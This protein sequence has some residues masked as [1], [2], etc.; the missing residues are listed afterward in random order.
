MAKQ[1][2][3]ST[4]TFKGII[5]QF[6]IALEK[7]FELQEGESVFIET[8]GDI[9]VIGDDSVQIESKYFNS[10]LTELDQNIWKTIYNW[11]SD[12]FPFDRFRSLILLTTQTVRSNSP[13]YDWNSKNYNQRHRIFLDIKA[14]FLRQRKKS[15]ETTKYIE[16]IFDASRESKLNK[17]LNLFY[18]DHS[19]PD[20]NEY[21]D[22]IKGQ[23]SKNVPSIRADQ[24]MN[25]MFGYILNPK[26][27]NNKW[28]VS[29]NDFAQEVRNVTCKLVET[30]TVFPEKIAFDSINHSDCLSSAFVEKIKDIE[31]HEV[32]NEAIVSYVQT[33]EIILQEFS[34]SPTIRR[35]LKQYE[36]DVK[37]IF[38]SRHRRCSRSC[39]SAKVIEMS[40]DFY[41]E[42]MISDRGTFY[43][44]NS[45]PV[46]FFKGILQ[47]L[48][49]ENEDMV[50]MLKNQL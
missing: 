26:I 20:D 36:D 37:N 41:D 12:D 30:T 2:N 35:S 23:Y 8:Y 3:D 45:V 42:I 19:K 24:Y 31:Y 17:L 15:A 4:K 18:I 50:W 13:W 33:K 25:S 27:I 22:K 34:L 7:C 16:Y 46:F 9:S 6:L 14:K 11:M 1:A 5:Y 10:K 48:T 44:F 32:V 39:N 38:K 47:I 49:D 29:Y 40:Q 28:E 21:Y 43:I